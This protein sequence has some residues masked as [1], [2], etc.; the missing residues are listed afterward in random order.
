M[1]GGAGVGGA[2]DQKT[3]L[4]M[5]GALLGPSDLSA[6]RTPDSKHM[7]RRS[8]VPVTMRSYD[9]FNILVERHEEAQKALDR[10]LPEVAAQHLGDIGLFDAEQTRR[11]RPV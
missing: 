6:L 1:V 7:R 2:T 10:K 4:R 8:D 9:D 11:P 3:G 5:G